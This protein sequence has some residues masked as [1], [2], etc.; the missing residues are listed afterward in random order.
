MVKKIVSAILIAVLLIGVPVRAY[1]PNAAEECVLAEFIAA[2]T[3]DAPYAV[4]LAMA[5]AILNRVDDSRYPET[6]SGVLSALGYRT[7]RRTEAY[8]A[9]LS[10]V[11]T[12]AAGMDIT[13]G[14]TAWA[15]EGSVEAALMRVTF[16]AAGWVFGE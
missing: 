4:K 1:E 16:S 9:A 12:A 15:R 11:R 14:A 3:G 2:K 10:A 8:G 7:V 5:A 13:E 6:V